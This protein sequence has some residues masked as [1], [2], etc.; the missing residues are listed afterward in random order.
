MPIN[1]KPGARR[2]RSNNDGSFSLANMRD[3]FVSAL[4]S[5]TKDISRQTTIDVDAFET[6]LRNLV[7]RYG[8]GLSADSVGQFYQEASVNDVSSG[9]NIPEIPKPKYN[10]AADVIVAAYDLYTE[11]KTRE[12]VQMLA[13]ALESDGIQELISALTITNTS[14]EVA[15]LASLGDIDPNAEVNADDGE[16]FDA[17]EPV[18]E[19]PEEEPEPEA[20]VPE[21]E[22]VP[23]EEEEPTEAPTEEEE[24]TEVDHSE[25][26]EEPIDHDAGMSEYELYGNYVTKYFPDSYSYKHIKTYL[27]GKNDVWDDEE[28]SNYMKM[29]EKSDFDIISMHT[30][31]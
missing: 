9:V 30:W 11:G 13:N 20:S 5:L 31:I 21:E 3:S 12:S 19:L 18:P 15:I 25:L 7:I 6:D 10:L 2:N 29:F 4:D 23:E 8:K 28:V 24:H 16:G 17:E 22:P 27:G 26:G 14:T 1:S